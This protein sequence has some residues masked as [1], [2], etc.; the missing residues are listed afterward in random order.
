MADRKHN[1]SS[2]YIIRNI[3]NL[4]SQ[5]TTTVGQV[6][7]TLNNPPPN[8]LRG[9]DIPG[10]TYQG[11]IPARAV[12]P[13]ASQLG[14]VAFAGNS[15]GEMKIGD[16]SDP[17]GA[18]LYSIG[19][20]ATTGIVW[21]YVI[22]YDSD[23]NNVLRGWM[24]AVDGTRQAYFTDVTAHPDGGW[25]ATGW[26]RG[27][28]TKV[29]SNDG[30]YLTV[31]ARS[32]N[33]DYQAIWA[34]YDAD[35]QLL[36]ARNSGF[37]SDN[38]AFTGPQIRGGGIC[39]LSDGRIFAMGY[40]LH[41][42]QSAGK[43]ATFNEAKTISY[44]IVT[45]GASA[46]STFGTWLVELDKTT[47]EGLSIDVIDH[48]PVTAGNSQNI[49]TSYTNL[50]LVA[51]HDDTYVI[52]STNSRGGP[53]TGQGLNVVGRGKTGEYSTREFTGGYSTGY[54]LNMTK[55]A[56]DGAPLS[57]ITAKAGGLTPPV[58]NSS[59]RYALMMSVPAIH[60]NGDVTFMMQSDYN[61]ANTD[62]DRNPVPYASPLVTEVATKSY[63]FIRTNSDFD[64]PT[65]VGISVKASEQATAGASNHLASIAPVSDGYYCT[66]SFTYNSSTV[67]AKFFEDVAYTDSVRYGSKIMK[68]SSAG[69]V[70]W[71]ATFDDD[72]ASRPHRMPIVGAF[73][74]GPAAGK[75]VAISETQT[76]N[77]VTRGPTNVSDGLLGFNIG[78]TWAASSEPNGQTSQLC[79]IA[80]D[81]DGE[82]ITEDCFAIASFR[83]GGTSSDY[84]TI[85][86]G[87]FA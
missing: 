6:P 87:K 83:Q 67:I 15:V 38:I 28:N 37:V 7:L 24:D 9:R 65:D 13:T 10:G 36:W 32:A 4:T 26:T 57:S 79:Y 47:G 76:S 49:Q 64:K 52:L 74:T 1:F 5:Q 42:N 54:K 70:Q 41:S 12:L 80:Y 58:N 60:S 16:K 73:E 25:V 86:K 61:L 78:D 14:Q 35:G 29:Y 82:V 84:K 53:A 77:A 34:R 71:L 59:E 21:G 66:L 33:Q 40:V 81:S 39:T 30:T 63:S 11:K 50:S 19:I 51:G 20:P 85:R 44:P 18:S 56:V 17:T 75:I 31:V 46:G 23:G 45:S 2:D 27:D 55:F 62:I 8:S 3:G 22:A 68:L 43:M 69:V 48:G 72:A